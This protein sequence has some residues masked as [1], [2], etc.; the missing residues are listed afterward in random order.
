[1]TTAHTQIKK[2]AC[3]KSPKLNALGMS[4]IKGA[5]PENED[6]CELLLAHYV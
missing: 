2:S 1:M 4:I 6:F 5:H 3:R